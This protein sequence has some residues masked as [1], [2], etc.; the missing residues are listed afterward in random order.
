MRRIAAVIDVAFELFV[1]LLFAA[2]VLAAVGGVAVGLY[3]AAE[4]L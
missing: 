2:Y 4:Q 1:G 3:V